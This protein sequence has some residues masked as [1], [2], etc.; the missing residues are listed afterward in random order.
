MGN[1]S[2][3]SRSGAAVGAFEVKLFDGSPETGTVIDSI[4]VPGLGA[5]AS[6]HVELEWPSVPDAAEHTLFLWVDAGEL[7]GEIAG[8]R[9]RGD[10]VQVGDDFVIK[11]PVLLLDVTGLAIDDD[12]VDR[13]IDAIIDSAKTGKIGDG[14]IF[15]TNLEN[16]VRIRTGES[17][18]TAL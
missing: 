13:V 5:G 8:C 9:V 7:H 6:T 11:V 14:K 17:G 4:S 16:V 10:D 3:S 2:V 15:V 1:P 12:L 18:S